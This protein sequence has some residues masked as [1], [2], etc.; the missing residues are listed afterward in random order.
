MKIS[1]REQKDICKISVSEKLC[2][3]L[4]DDSEKH[5][6]TNFDYHT[7]LENRIQE[8]ISKKRDIRGNVSKETNTS[9]FERRDEPRNQR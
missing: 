3:E 6:T 5:F 1:D 8:R 4:S 9:P 7:Y 2:F